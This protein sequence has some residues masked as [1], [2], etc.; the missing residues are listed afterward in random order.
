M[1]KIKIFYIILLWLIIIIS[2]ACLFALIEKLFDF[3][4][5][6]ISD[7]IT[8]IKGTSIMRI[9]SSMILSYIGINITQKI[10]KKN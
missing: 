4:L 5:L 10:W 2:N 1:K 6:V 8:V 7:N 3:S 9:I